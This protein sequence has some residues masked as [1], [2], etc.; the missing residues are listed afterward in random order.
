MLAKV[1]NLI[2]KAR[3]FLSELK[4]V[5]SSFPQASKKTTTR[6]P[7]FRKFINSNKA[8]LFEASFFG[9]REGGS[10]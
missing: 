4:F 5:I 9:G 1:S 7:F 2:I 10:L 8:G 6:K 3:F